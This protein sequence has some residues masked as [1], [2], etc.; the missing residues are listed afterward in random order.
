MSSDGGAIG[1]EAPLR[2]ASLGGEASRRPPLVA[3]HLSSRF[4]GFLGSDELLRWRQ[5]RCRRGARSPEA[6][7]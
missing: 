7:G 2:E 5:V 6:L 3:R 4:E 1:V